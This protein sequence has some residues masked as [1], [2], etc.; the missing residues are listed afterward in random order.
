MAQCL[1]QSPFTSITLWGSPKET[2]GWHSHFTDHKTGAGVTCQA[3][4]WQSWYLNP[5]F[6][7]PKPVTLSFFG[8]D[9]QGHRDSRIPLAL[10]FGAVGSRA[11]PSC[12]LHPAM[13]GPYLEK[14]TFAQTHK[15]KSFQNMPMH[16]CSTYIHTQRKYT[17]SSLTCTHTYA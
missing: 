16:A 10:G 17:H 7:I 3:S 15:Q 13:L 2:S 4:R 11:L 12:H 8:S 6:G 9:R 5:A 1:L 14:L